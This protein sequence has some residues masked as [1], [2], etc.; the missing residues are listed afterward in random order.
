MTVTRKY[1]IKATS[2]GYSIKILDGTE[3]IAHYVAGGTRN[4]TKTETFRK[5][6]IGYAVGEL[7]EQLEKA[8]EE[9]DS[10]WPDLGLDTSASANGSD[11]FATAEPEAT[12]PQGE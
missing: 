12:E 3:E 1:D 10:A 9:A 2:N 11:A 7:R 8:I 5:R 6:V 4:D